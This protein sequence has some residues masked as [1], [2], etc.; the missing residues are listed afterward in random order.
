M[1]QRLVDRDSLAGSA[2]EVAPR[3]LGCR[4]V[5]ARPG[6]PV[7]SGVIVETEAYGGVG[8]DEASHTF[9][10]RTERNAVMFGP[11][12]RL[13]VYRI[14]GMHWCAN[15]VVGADGDGTAV[16]VR[17]LSPRMGVDVM[18]SRRPKARRASDL[19]S[20]PGKLCAALGIDG[21]DDG[22]DLCDSRS[23]L[24]LRTG[25]HIDRTAIRR[26]PRVG[27]TKAVDRPWRFAIAD[28]PNV[29]RPRP[30]LTDEGESDR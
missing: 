1:P 21:S 8:D 25:R 20:G 28:D 2:V 6:Q 7:V 22:V 16:L 14:Y 27:I 3:L 30:R 19:T 9:R 12:G 26:G 11:A 13:Y 18:E 5:A 4:L 15:V 29:S 10:G 17:A 24:Q 23:P